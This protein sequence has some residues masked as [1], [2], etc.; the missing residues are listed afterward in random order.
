MEHFDSEE[1]RKLQQ[2][3]EEHYKRLRQFSDN[4]ELKKDLI[5]KINQLEDGLAP[6]IE[7]NKL[8]IALTQ[9]EAD[10]IAE[11]L[12]KI[13]DMAQRFS[14]AELLLSHKLLIKANAFFFHVK[15]LAEE[16][17]EEAKKVYEELLPSYLASQKERLDGLESQN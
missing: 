6:L 16:G 8:G 3:M 15:K 13:Q 4:P 2:G 14:D 1:E 7:K 9:D 5:E 17:N 12:P 10:L 11:I